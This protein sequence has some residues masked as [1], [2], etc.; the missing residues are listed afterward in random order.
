[1]NA[2]IAKTSDNFAFVIR[3][4][5]SNTTAT[6]W[7]VDSGALQHMTL[8][9]HFFD[10]YQLVLGRKM[11][12]SDNGMVKD[13]SKGSILVETRVKDRVRSIT[14]HDVLHVPKMHSNLLSVSKL[15][16]RGLKVHFNSLGCM[17]RASNSE[18]LAVALLEFN[19]YQL[20]TN[21]MN[22]AETSFLARFDENS[23]SFELWHKRLGHLN[24]N[25]MK[26]LQS[27]VRGMNVGAAQDDVHSTAF[28]GCVK[29]RQ[30]R[31]PFSR[32]RGAGGC[33]TSRTCGCSVVWLMRRCR[34]KGERSWM[35]R[36]SN[37]C[38]SDI[39]KVRRRISSFAWRQRKSSRVRTWC[40]LKTKR[41]WRIVQVGELRN[42]RR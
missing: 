17:V 24:A 38:S 31:R 16:S 2:N 3:D 21:V 39:A 28:G 20:D 10:S 36:A 32:R 15:I 37:V 8:H 42:H 27:I 6:R 19:L 11:F 13:I 7:I 41:I 22:G 14:I 35:Q 23:H 5:A 26:M 18:M 34:N 9:K 30:T 29:G 25:S 12:M 40:F 33:Y 4:G 1:M